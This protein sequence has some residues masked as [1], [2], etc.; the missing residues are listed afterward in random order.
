MGYSQPLTGQ[1]EQ[2]A[3]ALYS[4]QLSN[5]HMISPKTGWKLSVRTGDLV[6]LKRLISHVSGTYSPGIVGI[7]IGV[8]EP[9]PKDPAAYA[10]VKFKRGIVTCYWGE[11]EVIS[12]S[13]FEG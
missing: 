11:L 6:R 8:Q 5:Q 2:C 4:G 1:R 7:V 10:E 9:S 13:R 3:G 12:E